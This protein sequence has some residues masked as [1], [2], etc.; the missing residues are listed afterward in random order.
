MEEPRELVVVACSLG[1]EDHAARL[2]GWQEIRARAL[3]DAL[4]TRRGVRLIFRN[5]PGVEEDLRQ[6]VSLESECCSFADW[7]LR[8]HS[9]DLVLDVSAD[10]DASA[11]VREMLGVMNGS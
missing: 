2:Q 8:V 1:P 9:G 10:G 11:V 3:I 5:D 4:A 7:S 6:L